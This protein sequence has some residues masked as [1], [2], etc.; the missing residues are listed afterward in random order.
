MKHAGTFAVGHQSFLKACGLGLNPAV[1][2]LVMAR[3]T[4]R[5]H[6]TTAWSANA[7]NVY[8]GMSWRR[9]KQAIDS[10]A[11][12]GLVSPKPRQG[13]RRKLAKSGPLIWLP[14]E[15]VTGATDETPPVARIRQTQDGMLLR[16][17][18]E[19]Y[20]AHSLLDEGGVDTK[21]VC[22]RYERT[23][24]GGR[25]EFDVWGFNR[26]NMVVWETALTKPHYRAPTKEELAQGHNQAKE[27]FA[28][29]ETLRTLGL[30]EWV[31]YLREGEDGEPIHPLSDSMPE[32]SGLEEASRAAG[33]ALLSEQ[34]AQQAEEHSLVVPIRR[35][36]QNAAVVGVAR[37]RYR[38]RTK[39]T[40][41]WW[42]DHLARCQAAMDQFR[43]ITEKHQ[44][45]EAA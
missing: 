31:P 11:R 19:L 27:F 13:T 25:A 32:A 12:A 9:A 10:L 40:S 45:A 1:A 37:L 7:V 43:Q 29:L 2:F 30:F 41:Q 33:C 4:G 28:R 24:L 23:K 34:Q 16:L 18:I 22:H 14:N 15:L 6:S 3:G 17:F 5:D 44:M 36:L 8:S 38:P 26:T 42:A 39:L 20:S 35:H 21:L